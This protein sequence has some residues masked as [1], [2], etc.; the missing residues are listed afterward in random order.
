MNDTS[1]FIIVRGFAYFPEPQFSSHHSSGNT[2]DAI[3]VLAIGYLLSWVFL[4]ALAGIQE[5]TQLIKTK[6][7]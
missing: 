6:I 3:G 5:L 2:F 1:Q 7:K 4:F